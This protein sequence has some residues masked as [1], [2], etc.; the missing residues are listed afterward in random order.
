[1]TVRGIGRWTAE[2]AR[3]LWAAGPLLKSPR[4]T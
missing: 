2:M 4:I 3:Y 1:M